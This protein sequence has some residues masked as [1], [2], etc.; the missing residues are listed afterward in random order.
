M[1]GCKIYLTFLEKVFITKT[2]IQCKTSCTFKIDVFEIQ[3]NKNIW[4]LLSKYELIFLD[5][6]NSSS[7]PSEI[8]ILQSPIS[9]AFLPPSRFLSKFDIAN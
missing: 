4:K 1:L 3:E 7:D 5:K 9:R 2:F 8:L 6:V